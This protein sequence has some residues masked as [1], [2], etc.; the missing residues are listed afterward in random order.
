M[1]KRGLKPWLL[2]LH[3]VLA[4]GLT[5]L[6]LLLPRLIQHSDKLP[7]ANA[8]IAA[9]TT[10]FAAAVFI[11]I[12]V[13]R[14]G[15]RRLRIATMIPIV[16]LIL[17]L[18]GIGPFF[19]FGQIASTKGTVQLIDLTYSARPLARI[20]NQIAPPDGTIAVYKVRRDVEFGISVF[21]RRSGQLQTGWDTLA[22]T[23]SCSSWNAINIKLRQKRRRAAEPLFVCPAQNLVVYQ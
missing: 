8:L 11:L 21:D 4:G 2:I 10:G 1:R 15:I 12:T 20:L 17:F 22:A 6:V 18:Y 3:G 14:F 5:S 23:Y 9:G 7:P 16:I 13:A 19:G